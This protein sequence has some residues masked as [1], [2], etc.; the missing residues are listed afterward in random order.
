MQTPYQRV[1]GN[2]PVVIQLPGIPGPLI[3]ACARVGAGLACSCALA[4]PP[5]AHVVLA[6][7]FALACAR[8]VGRVLLARSCAPRWP[9]A[10]RSLVRA[11]LTA[12]FSLARAPRWRGAS[13]C[14]PAVARRLESREGVEPSST[15]LQPVY[16]AGES[17]RWACARAPAGAGRGNRTHIHGLEDRNPSAWTI[18]AYVYS[19]SPDEIEE[20]VCGSRFRVSRNRHIEFALT[21]SPRS[22]RTVRSETLLVPSLGRS[23]DHR[24]LRTVIVTDVVLPGIRD[25]PSLGVSSWNRRESHPQPPRCHRGTL[26]FELRS[27]LSSGPLGPRWS[28]GES[29]PDLCDAN[30]LFSC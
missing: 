27:R 6:A 5:L 3:L 15:G 14:R 29:H 25:C 13:R 18:P 26:L 23:P 1:Q 10:S 12:C 8:R 11:A 24:Y 28:D 4:L 16:L 7:C 9:R 20:D 17:A 30:A 2:Q 21:S 22:P 19:I